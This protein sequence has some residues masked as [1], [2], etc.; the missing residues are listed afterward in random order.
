M[1]SG[2]FVDAVHYLESIFGENEN[3]E[4]SVVQRIPD[5]I[6]YSNTFL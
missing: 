4:R 6:V 5:I 2:D 3:D 1:K